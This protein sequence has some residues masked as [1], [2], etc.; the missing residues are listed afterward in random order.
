MV[1]GGMDCA[2][3]VQQKSFASSVIIPI[4]F[5]SNYCLGGGCC[6]LNTQ[7]KKECIQVFD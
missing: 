6:L 1:V 5:I 3:K 4:L 2:S 7:I